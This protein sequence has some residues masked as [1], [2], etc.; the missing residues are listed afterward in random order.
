MDLA[1]EVRKDMLEKNLNKI[2]VTLTGDYDYDEL[3]KAGFL[4]LFSQDAEYNEVLFE[5]FGLG[6]VSFIK[7]QELIF[8]ATYIYNYSPDEMLF[9]FNNK[10]LKYTKWMY[11]TI[12]NM[13]THGE[14]TCDSLPLIMYAKDKVYT[15]SKR[16]RTN[17]LMFRTPGSVTIH[18]DEIKD[19]YY[20]EWKVIPVTRYAKGMSKGLFYSEEESS[21]CGTFYYYEPES[22]TYLTY[23]RMLTARN[24]TDAARLL[25]K[26]LGISLGGFYKKYGPE[27]INSAYDID[28]Q[29]TYLSDEMIEKRFYDLFYTNRDR[30]VLLKNYLTNNP[31][32]KLPEDLI[33]SPSELIKLY[34][35]IFIYSDRIN[36]HLSERRL[37][38]LAIKIHTKRY[39]GVFL[40]LYAKEDLYDQLICRAGKDAGYDLI[41]LTHMVGSHQVVSE[42]LDTRDR[43]I[44]F[45]SL[46]FTY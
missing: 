37:E 12:Q 32:N 14:E 21:F 23:N 19:G 44:S 22:S 16:P 27:I 3:I 20:K 45:D 25:A 38:E 28:I 1:E 46:I 29:D 13:I 36:T 17:M 40:D 6:I 11:Q 31:R 34:P 43:N 33:L 15:I 42:I 10:T 2:V 26:G 39:M 30:D 5:D 18:K 7:M 35:Q 8:E 24:K 9:Y 41:L 4:P